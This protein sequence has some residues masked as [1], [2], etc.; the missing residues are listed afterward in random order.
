MAFGACRNPSRINRSASGSRGAS[1]IVASLS[2]KAVTRLRSS[3]V[4]VTFSGDDG[5]YVW[6]GRWRGNDRPKNNAP[7]IAS[8]QRDPMGGEHLR[9]HVAGEIGVFP[10]AQ[11]RER[12]EPCELRVDK[13]GVAHHQATIRKAREEAW[14][15]RGE[16]G[17]RVEPI[18]AG[19]GRI[20]RQPAGRGAAAEPSAQEVEQEP[21]AVREAGPYRQ[22]A[23]A[24]SHPGVR[25]QGGDRGGERSV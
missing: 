11:V 19:E 6:L 15:Q 4:M 20:G 21:L 18:G 14:K 25:G 12:V 16:I 23:P 9:E 8:G 24:V 13:T 22:G 5:R 7:F 17:V 1:S 3:G 2:N 10:L